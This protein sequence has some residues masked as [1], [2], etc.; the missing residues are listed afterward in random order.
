MSY[1]NLS[2]A[3]NLKNEFLFWMDQKNEFSFI[4]NQK[5]KFLARID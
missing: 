5:N 1:F 2:L 4:V 3:L